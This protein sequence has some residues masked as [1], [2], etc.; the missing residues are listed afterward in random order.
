MITVIAGENSF[1]NERLLIRIATEFDGEPEKIDGEILETKQLS[2]LLM[3]MS[4]FAAKRLVIIKNMSANKAVWND[5]DQWIPRVSD[6][7]HV[8]LVDSKPDKRTKTFKVLQKVAKIHESKLFT[9]RDIPK[10]EQWVYD[11]A[12]RLAVKL[13]KKSAHM[14]VARVGIDQWALIRAL[15]KLAVLDEVT[16]EVIANIIEP[17][18]TE[19]AFGLFEAALRGDDKKVVHMLEI[20]AKTEDP[21]RLFGLISGQAFQLATLAV[22]EVPEATVASDLSVHPFVISKLGPFAKRLGKSGA[23]EAMRYFAEADTAMKTM[24]IDPWLLMERAL[25]KTAKI[26]R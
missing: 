12:L 22:A 5:F 24:A 21:Y 10:V 19:N 18:P 7:I 20:L 4:L 6:D 25:L 16:P 11:E 26:A 9:D 15:Q 8:I 3:G 23:V 1:E 17:N 2:D 14:L 13:D